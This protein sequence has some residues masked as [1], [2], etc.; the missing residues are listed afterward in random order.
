M[1]NQK[2]KKKAKVQKRYASRNKFR[3]MA[4]ASREFGGLVPF[5]YPKQPPQATPGNILS[6]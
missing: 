5:Q 4:K 2:K 1:Y 6:G 3:Q